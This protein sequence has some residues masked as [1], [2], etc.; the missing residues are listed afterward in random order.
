MCILDLCL[1][2][3]Y[4]SRCTWR[5]NEFPKSDQ[6]NVS[7]YANSSLLISI[8]KSERF[9]NTVH[10]T[11]LQFESLKNMQKQNFEV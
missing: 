9:G 5:R 11:M 7:F 1:F 10:K 8:C 3:Y 4:C 2:V 6:W